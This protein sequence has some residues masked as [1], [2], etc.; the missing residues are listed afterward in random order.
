MNL[1]LYNSVAQQKLTSVVPWVVDLENQS[2]RNNIHFRDIPKNDVDAELRPT[3]QSICSILGKPQLAELIIDRVNR[4][5]LYR[6]YQVLGPRD[7]LCCIH[8]FNI[9][10]E[11]MRRAWQLDQ[12]EHAGA[13]ILI[14][15][16]ISRNRLKPLGRHTLGGT[17]FI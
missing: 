15:S 5:I 16:D 6:T 13:R 14:L 4:V 2:R 8:F 10:D 11:I 1:V 9:K 17:H 3:I 12:I 7:V